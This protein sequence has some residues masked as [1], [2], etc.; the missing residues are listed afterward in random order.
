MS[1]KEIGAV[2]GAGRGAMAG[3]KVGGVWGAVIGAVIGGISGGAAGHAAKRARIYQQRASRTQ[4]MLQNVQAAIQRREMVRQTYVARAEQLAA[5]SA[6]GET[7]MLSSGYGGSM[8]SLMSRA[9][10]NLQVFDAA[11]RDQVQM[12]FWLRKAAK[13]SAQSSN[14]SGFMDLAESAT[15]FVG[16]NLEAGKTW[17]GGSKGGGSTGGSTGGG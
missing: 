10:R 13:K 9:G 14:I 3:A 11:A 7:G 4:G 6:S 1:E 17:Y 15:N 2:S 16:G 12:N 5:A 8:S